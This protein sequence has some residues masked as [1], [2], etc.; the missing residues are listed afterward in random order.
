MP[1]RETDRMTRQA[2]PARP[3]QTANERSSGVSL[4]RRT[5][6]SAALI[7]ACTAV[8]SGETALSAERSSPAPPAPNAAAATPRVP[9][10]QETDDYKI[11]ALLLAKELHF[12]GKRF[13]LQTETDGYHAQIES[14]DPKLDPRYDHNPC[15]VAA[16]HDYNAVNRRGAVSLRSIE[17]AEHAVHA[18]RSD[19]DR[20]LRHGWDA[21]YTKYEGAQGFVRLARPGYSAAGSTAVAYGSFSRGGRAGLGVVVWLRERGGNWEVVKEISGWRS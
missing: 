20:V 9:R 12:A 19:L 17:G 11:Y 1:T 15:L 3:S 2:S 6:N 21:F 8:G 10:S 5:I 16:L 18:S 14:I 4:R 13:V 7:L